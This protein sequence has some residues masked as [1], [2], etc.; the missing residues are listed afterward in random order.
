MPSSFSLLF[1]PGSLPEIKRENSVA[2]RARDVGRA[3]VSGQPTT[4]ICPWE[5]LLDCLLIQRL[6]HPQEAR[7]QHG[8]LLRGVCDR[9]VWLCGSR[10]ALFQI[11]SIKRIWVQFEL[12]PCQAGS[13][14][15]MP[16][17]QAVL[18]ETFHLCSS[19]PARRRALFCQTP[20]PNF[21]TFDFCPCSSAKLA[22][23]MNGA[24]L[25]G[26]NIR[27]S[28]AKATSGSSNN[29]SNSHQ[30]PAV[31]ALPQR[32]QSAPTTH[33]ANLPPA[34]ASAYQGLQPSALLQA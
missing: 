17:L 21:T 24:E 11:A 15:S 10:L 12:P 25:G 26:R 5:S 6:L 32:P 33:F 34:L 4:Q 19:D 8:V 7:I 14:A 20:E 3:A 1:L 29:S 9:K 2:A 13:C 30:A 22:V 28:M 18:V 23:A 31:P 16:A 27:V